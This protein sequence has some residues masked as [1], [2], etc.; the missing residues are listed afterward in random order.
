MLRNK[1]Y[2]KN[3]MQINHDNTNIEYVNS[4]PTYALAVFAVIL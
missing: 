1:N 2:A 4:L 3:A